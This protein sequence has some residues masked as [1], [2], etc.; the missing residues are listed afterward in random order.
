MTSARR[1][2]LCLV[3]SADGA[4]TLI[5]AVVGACRMLSLD[6]LAPL[7]TRGSNFNGLRAAAYCALAFILA[8][9]VACRIL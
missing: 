6:P 8:G 1:N 5:L 2:L 9:D 4:V 7:V 3:R